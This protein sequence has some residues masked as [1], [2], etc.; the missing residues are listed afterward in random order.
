[1]LACTFPKKTPKP[2]K[3]FFLSITADFVFYFTHPPPPPLNCCPSSLSG[4]GG[5]SELKPLNA[6][7]DVSA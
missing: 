5:A 7:A 6:F 4:G 1:M 3:G 2:H